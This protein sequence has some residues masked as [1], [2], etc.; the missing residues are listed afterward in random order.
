MQAVTMSNTDFIECEECGDPAT[1]MA[2]DLG[3]Q[4]YPVCRRCGHRIFFD[5]AELPVG[6]L[7]LMGLDYG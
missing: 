1:G 4:S 6:D 3:N 7:E 5:Y 2:F